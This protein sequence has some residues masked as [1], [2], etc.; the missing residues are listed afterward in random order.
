[1]VQAEVTRP[2]LGGAGGGDVIDGL[3]VLAMKGGGGPW[4]GKSRWAVVSSLVVLT[5]YRRLH[6]LIYVVVRR[7]RSTASCGVG[8]WAGHAFTTRHIILSML[9]TQIE[10]TFLLNH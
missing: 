3:G 8:Y 6:A 1:V 4:V 9:I 2:G 10:F 7:S 5:P